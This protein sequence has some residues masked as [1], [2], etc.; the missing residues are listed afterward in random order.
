MTLPYLPWFPDDFR[1]S[2]SVEGMSAPAEL[3]YR[4]A[5]DAAWTHDGLP[6]GSREVRRLTRWLEA[7]ED[8]MPEFSE[9]WRVV[10]VHFH[11][12][13]GRLRN[14]RQEKERTKAREAYLRRAH[15]ANQRWKK[16]CEAGCPAC[17]ADAAKQ[18]AMHDAVTGPTHVQLITHNSEPITD[19]STEEVSP[20]NEGSVGEAPTREMWDVWLDELKPPTAGRY[21]LTPTRKTKLRLLWNEQLKDAKDPLAG[22]RWIVRVVKADEWRR[23]QEV[24][25]SMPEYI[26]RNPETRERWMNAARTFARA[27][28]MLTAPVSSLLKRLRGRNG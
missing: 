12:D 16:P 10:S 19:S 4:R 8:G 7:Q 28:G 2:P 21:S 13:G 11:P 24:A 6:V 14:P 23:E 25:Y 5:L 27:G 20:S 22:L 18:D 26:A 9:V 17:A 15:A 1:T 3:L